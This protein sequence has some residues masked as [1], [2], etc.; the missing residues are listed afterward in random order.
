MR[1]S[2][3]IYASAL[4]YLGTKEVPG[5][6]TNA[7]IKAWIKQAAVWLDD[8]DSATAWCGCFRGAIGIE[9]AT[10]VP[11]THYRAASWE[12]W[13]D[14]VNLSRKDLWQK[15]DTIIMTRPGGNNVCLLDSVEGRHVWCL[16]GNQSDAVT[17]AK[18]PISRVTS[19]RR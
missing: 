6:R 2:A 5:P 14:P 12:F 11:A 18:F 15:G 9:T 7:K 16:G 8:D 19:V 10:G 13:G 3:I 1:K 4:K 17:I